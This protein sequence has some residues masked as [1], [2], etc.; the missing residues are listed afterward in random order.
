MLNP[1][2]DSGV[3]DAT[4]LYW[5][6]PGAIV[7]YCWSG[8]DVSPPGQP[9]GQGAARSW[10]WS[11]PEYPNIP[12]WQHCSPCEQHVGAE[13]GVVWQTSRPTGHAPAH[14]ASS[15][16]MGVGGAQVSQSIGPPVELLDEEEDE[17]LLDEDEDEEDE[18]LDEEELLLD[19]E[20]ED[21]E[22]VPD[23]EDDEAL[24]DEDDEEE[25]PLDEDD[26][27]LEDALLLLEDAFEALEFVLGAPPWPPA[28]PLPCSPMVTVGP[29]PSAGTRRIS[30]DHR[31]M[32]S[33]LE[34]ARIDN[35]ASIGQGMIRDKKIR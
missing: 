3:Q 32:I 18:L 34:E 2:T 11:P 28:P 5:L 26:A 23:E 15:T 31:F 24:D 30:A 9:M 21:D 35:F 14:A 1:H 7:Q 20:D 19:D 16:Q 10:H 13:P 4:Q 8:H 12:A 27:P 33:P 22:L 6:A 29:H 17:L 25:E